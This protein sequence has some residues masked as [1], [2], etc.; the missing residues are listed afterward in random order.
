MHSPYWSPPDVPTSPWAHTL[1]TWLDLTNLISIVPEGSITCRGTGK[2]SLIDHIF[3]NMAFLE[4]P[5]FPAT[6]S[7]S[8]ECSI[9]S[10]HIALFVE[11]PLFTPPPSP[12]SQP[13]WI[14]EDQMEQEWKHTFAKFPRPLISDVPSLIRA[15]TDLLTLTHATC[16]R[17]FA[18]KSSHGNKG[19]AWWND[20][21]RIA[22]AE[23]SR[24][25]GSERCHLSAILCTT[26]RH[27]KWD[28]LEHL[29]TDPSTSIWDLAKW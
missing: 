3:I 18:K 25:H 28:W 29:V 2:A 27:A 7:I 16:D 19:L 26:L 6:C 17:F 9:S 5:V 4:N 13:G 21:C 20:V 15:S 14:I 1:E 22:A 23:V 12:P 10:D 8:F 11:L 24:A